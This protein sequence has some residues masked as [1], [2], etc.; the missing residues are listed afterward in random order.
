MRQVIKARYHDGILEPLEPLALADDAEVQVTVET[1][2]AV[3]VD[4]LLQ[5]AT[6]VYQGFTAEQI[7][8]VESIAL[9]RRRFFREPAA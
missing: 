5:R 7:A 4:E 8:Q 6:L 1:E 2:S 3:S 9:D